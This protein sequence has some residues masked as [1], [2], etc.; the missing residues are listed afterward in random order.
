MATAAAPAAVTEPNI[1][2][3]YAEAIKI[4][5]V[6][7]G[8]HSICYLRPTAMDVAAERSQAP[9]LAACTGDGGA[10]TRLRPRVSLA[11]RPLVVSDARKMRSLEQLV[12]S[13]MS[14]RYL[15]QQERLFDAF[16]KTIPA[17]YRD[18]LSLVLLELT[19][20][21]IVRLNTISYLRRRERAMERDRLQC[22]ARKDFLTCMLG[23]GCLIALIMFFAYTIVVA[24][25]H[26]SS[27]AAAAA[28][29][30]ATPRSRV[31]NGGSRII[32]PGDRGY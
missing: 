16:L 23:A 9:P 31:Y 6:L 17:G 15:E 22:Q 4:T 24:A 2:L 1:L 21:R 12:A 7:K 28:A 29:A 5:M 8:L 14:E 25:E 13:S 27:K 30:A 10:R 19:E 3:S 20:S 18:R 11:G 26:H 32:R